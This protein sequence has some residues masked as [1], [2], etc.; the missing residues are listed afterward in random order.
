VRRGLLTVL[1][2]IALSC[3]ASGDSS[4]DFDDGAGTPPPPTTP[5][6]PALDLCDGD[7]ECV[8]A[9]S[10]CCAC[11]TF[12]VSRDSGWS[13]ACADVPCEPAPQCAPVTPVCSPRGCTLDCDEVPCELTC[14]DGFAADAAGCLTCACREAPRS[15][16]QSASECA[17]VPAD[18]CGCARGGADTAVLAVEVESH[19]RGL[20]CSADARCP[21]VD[22][23]PQAQAVVCRRG[24]C[25][26][27]EIDPPVGSPDLPP[28]AC[29]RADLPP[30]PAGTRC[31]LNRSSDADEDG[32]GICA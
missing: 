6:P 18:C 22:V 24:R 26:L 13:A 2:L 27:V 32:V 11:P 30:C 19:Q 14:A 25:E 1:A 7:D 8:P 28:G 4:E 17:R 15:G 10:T 3:G 31:I 5:P 29:G 9:A 23:C 20:A 16:C 12:A 21:E